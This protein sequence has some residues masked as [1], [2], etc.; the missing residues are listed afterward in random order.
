MFEKK[1]LKYFVEF[2]RLFAEFSIH[3]SASCQPILWNWIE[4]CVS[5]FCD[6]RKSQQWTQMCAHT[7]IRFCCCSCRCHLQYITVQILSTLFHRKQLTASNILNAFSMEQDDKVR[8]RVSER[9]RENGMEWHKQQSFHCFRR[10]TDCSAA[11]VVVIFSLLSHFNR[12]GFYVFTCRTRSNRRSRRE[13][14][15]KHPK[16]YR[17]CQRISSFIFISFVWLDLTRI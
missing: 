4:F 8:E 10:Y 1:V 6:C 11:A 9:E 17:I 7:W 2:V 5:F 14:E 13:T 16:T 3:S 12:N 15:E